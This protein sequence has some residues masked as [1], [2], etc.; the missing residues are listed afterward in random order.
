M[1]NYQAHETAVLDEGCQIGKGTKIWHFAH[2]MPQ[3]VIGDN[4]VV[5]QNV[6]IADGVKIGDRVK[7][8]NN[9]SLYAGVTC[10]DDVF[11]GPS[12]AFTNVINPRSAIPRKDRFKQT[13]IKKGASIG[14]NATVVC[15]RIIGEYA[16]IGAG[17]VVVKDAPPYALIVGNPG[18]QIGWV[19]EYGTRLRFDENNRAVCEESGQIYQL[20]E[21]KVT[22]IN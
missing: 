18:K 5:G 9:V 10:E 3:A 7:I 21:N 20:N 15:G 14:A 1:N 19:G 11:L 4:C 13:R 22:R 17:S 2:I 8:Q 12:C 6:F 16:L